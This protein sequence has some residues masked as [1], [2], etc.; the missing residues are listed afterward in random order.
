MSKHLDSGNL[1]LFRRHEHAYQMPELAEDTAAEA[2][3]QVD[4][5]LKPEDH[6]FIRHYLGYADVLLRTREN[7]RRAKVIEISRPDGSKRG[8]RMGEREAVGK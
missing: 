8:K 2:M 4:P 6:G 1:I 7:D 3:D 5:G